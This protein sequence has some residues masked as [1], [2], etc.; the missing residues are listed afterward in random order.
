MLSM[1]Y[2]ATARLDGKLFFPTL[3]KAVIILQT[4]KWKNFKISTQFI[5]FKTWEHND[6]IIILVFLKNIF[7]CQF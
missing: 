3:L 5:D 1:L 4:K 7:N 6:I 2:D